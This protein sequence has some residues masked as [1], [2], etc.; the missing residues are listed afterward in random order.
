MGEANE[1]DN[2]SDNEGIPTQVKYVVT[3]I[4]TIA[5]FNQLVN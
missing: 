3:A 5:M 1:E 2:E 4:Q